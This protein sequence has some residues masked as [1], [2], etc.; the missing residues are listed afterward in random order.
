MRVPS[1]IDIDRPILPVTSQPVR[2]AASKAEALQSPGNLGAK[3]D[4]L[5]PEKE[6]Q[7]V[8]LYVD[9]KK[10]RIQVVDP[11]IDSRPLELKQVGFRV[12]VLCA[13]GVK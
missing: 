7:W 12:L 11:V 10:R 8:H 13:W 4:D 9:I 1:I 2:I 6:L 3:I 5:Q